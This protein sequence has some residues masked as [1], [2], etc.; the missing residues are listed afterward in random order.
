MELDSFALAS[1]VCCTSNCVAT[2]ATTFW[3]CTEMQYVTVRHDPIIVQ[4]DTVHFKRQAVGVTAHCLHHLCLYWYTEESV[5]LDSTSFSWNLIISR[6]I[7]GYLSYLPPI[8]VTIFGDS[9]SLTIPVVSIRVP[10]E[11]ED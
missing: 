1:S 8:C 9:S 7:Q 11:F 5:P 3:G 6:R 10:F 2:S 4:L